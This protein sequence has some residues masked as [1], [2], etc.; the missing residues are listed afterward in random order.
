MDWEKSI[1][2]EWIKNLDDD[3]YKIDENTKWEDIPAIKTLKTIAEKWENEKPDTYIFPG[4]ENAI[5]KYNEAIKGDE[6]YKLQLNFPPHPFAGNP[7][8]PIWV[9]NLNPGYNK[10]A[11]DIDFAEK[12]Q[13]RQWSIDQLKGKI[14]CNYYLRMIDRGKKKKGACNWWKK[15]LLSQDICDDNIVMA[16][17][18][19]SLDYFP[20]QSKKYKDSGNDFKSTKLFK[21][22]IEWGKA[23]GVLFLI[24][25]RGVRYEFEAKYQKGYENI[26]YA[27]SQASWI[28]LGNLYRPKKI[29]YDIAKET[30]EQK[31]D[32]KQANKTYIENFLKEFSKKYSYKNEC[33]TCG[34]E[35]CTC[36]WQLTKQKQ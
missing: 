28:S 8:A 36:E 17:K 15:Y 4:D 16:D 11:D 30:K 21:K 10:D 2:T 13:G 35:K 25:R 6:D 22:I 19:F 24:M 12:S 27:V 26:M 9:I 3:T 18:F 34:Q 5:I 23:R 33:C 32:R 1:E 20:Y 14:F 31:E 7:Y 29:D